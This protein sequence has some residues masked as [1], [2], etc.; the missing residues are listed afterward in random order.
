MKTILIFLSFFLS[1]GFLF[2]NDAK[3]IF[4][5]GKVHV[6]ARGSDAWNPIKQG[7]LLGANQKI[8]TGNASSVT[9]LHG[10]SEIKLYQNTSLILEELPGAEKQDSLRLESGF[11]WFK[12]EELGKKGV[13]VTTPSSVAA[14][15]G[16]A[17][18]T[19]YD[20]KQKQAMN[21]T[22]HGSIEVRTLAG[23]NQIVSKGSGS[24]ISENSDKIE[25][26]SY[27]G[28][29]EKGEALPKFEEKVK[30]NPMMLG[31]VSCHKPK[32]WEAKGILKDEKYAK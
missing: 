2:A 9:L 19:L 24:A 8:R 27:K 3:V 21:C 10:K 14:V 15:R 25:L 17:F 28:E 22:C 4:V 6:Q 11:S 5:R 7:D 26:A 13:V 23:T 1:V 12:F 29:I 18:A 16:T 30:Q 31:C 20:T 32:G